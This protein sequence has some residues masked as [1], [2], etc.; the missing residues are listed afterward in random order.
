MQ[1]VHKL[2]RAVVCGSDMC[3]DMYHGV[4]ARHELTYDEA[5]AKVRN[6]VDDY[7][8]NEYEVKRRFCNYYK[9]YDQYLREDE[10]V[11]NAMSYLSGTLLNFNRELI[12]NTLV[13][14]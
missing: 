12:T 8:K 13:S 3:G 6:H 10:T 2:I 4:A 7:L 14:L 9:T 5:K 1:Q 11:Q